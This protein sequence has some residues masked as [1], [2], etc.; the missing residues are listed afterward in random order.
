MNKRD[1]IHKC[2]EK[3][4]EKLADTYK[5]GARGWCVMHYRRFSRNGDPQKLINDGSGFVNNSG[6]RMLSVRSKRVREHRQIMEKHLGRKLSPSEV[7]HH[8]NGDKLD[9]RLENLQ[10]MTRSEHVRHHHSEILLKRWP[11]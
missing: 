5:G 7:V 11:S 10:V 8:I 1:A 6:Y 4:C 2:K 9:N 3:G